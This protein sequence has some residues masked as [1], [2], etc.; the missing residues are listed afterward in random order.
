MYFFSNSIALTAFILM[1]PEKNTVLKE[2]NYCIFS[3]DGEKGLFIF[4]PVKIIYVNVGNY[5]A[6]IAVTIT[7]AATRLFWHTFII[8]IILKKT[9]P[10]S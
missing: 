8:I 4:F 1:M 5:S 3:K 10:S 6:A 9:L 2:N 7:V